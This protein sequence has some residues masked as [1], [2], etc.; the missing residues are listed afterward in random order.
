MTR[1]TSQSVAHNAASNNTQA[2][3]ADLQQQILKRAY[4]LFEERGH[5][6]GYADQDWLKAEEEILAKSRTPTRAA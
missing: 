5:V 2:Q 1:K 4:E 3:P 6:D